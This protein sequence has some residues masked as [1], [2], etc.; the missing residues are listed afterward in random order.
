MTKT[1]N[2][3]LIRGNINTII[4]KSLYS[5]DRYGYDIIREIEEKSHGQYILKQP[6]L[7][8]CLKRLESQ[9]FITSYWGEQSNGGRRKYYTLTDMGREV[10]IQSQD[11]YEFSRTIIDQLISERDYDL[12]SVEKPEKED[13]EFKEVD[14]EK[15]VEI[16]ATQNAECDETVEEIEEISTTVEENKVIESPVDTTE[17]ATTQQ[18]EDEYSI[19]SPENAVEENIDFESY[20]SE[21]TS[22]TSGAAAKEPEKHVDPTTFS[23]FANFMDEAHEESEQ[24]KENAYEENQTY[25]QENTAQEESYEDSASTYILPPQPQKEHSVTDD[26]LSYNSPAPSY[27]PS[28][29]YEPVQTQPAPKP[30][31][32][33]NDNEYKSS[34]SHLIDGFNTPFAEES[35]VSTEINKD[36]LLAQSSLSVKEKIQVKNFGKLTESM[37]EMGDTVKIRTPNSDAAKEYNQQF[38]YYRNKLRLWQSGALFLLMIV[39]TL[40]TYVIIKT[41]CGIHT[42]NDLG[43]Y[44]CAVM[45]CLAFPISAGILFLSN[46]FKRKRVEFNLRTSLIFRFIIMLQVILIVY[47]LCVYM[48]MPIAGS[49]EYTLFFTLPAVLSTNIPISA[50]IFNSL[51]KSKRFAVEN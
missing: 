34:L 18:Y 23:Y 3:D 16:N 10:F 46:P 26:F 45:F 2:S 21:G 29:S 35:A 17:S 4:L 49:T 6:T 30:T 20:L 31:T 39:E 51:Y 28:Y 5:G 22:Y 40:L 42:P 13:E 38:Y 1:I 48:G 12:D 44:I 41:G 37:R 9:G 47:A 24:A 50:I 25:E 36:T 19:V 15:D 8:S 27:A 11:E 7:Y 43:F 33:S 14:A 32:S